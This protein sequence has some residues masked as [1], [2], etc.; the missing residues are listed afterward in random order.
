[1]KNLMFL[2]TPG[3]SRFEFKERRKRVLRFVP[4]EPFLSYFAFILKGYSFCFSVVIKSS[5]SKCL[6]FIVY[7]MLLSL[8]LPKYLIFVFNYKE[9]N[10]DSLC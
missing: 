1:M 9:I 2:V 7:L 8:C 5:I 4:N 6:L 3:L 10:Y